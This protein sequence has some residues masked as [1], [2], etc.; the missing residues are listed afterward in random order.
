MTGMN[1]AF[2]VWLEYVERFRGVSDSI[3][4]SAICEE[5]GEPY[6]EV[7]WHDKGF[8]VDESYE[9]PRCR[10]YK[11]EDVAWLFGSHALALY[12]GSRVGKIQ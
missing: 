1:D 11:T 5:T 8:M 9:P 7:Y 3:G 10:K 6:V 12:F 4:N 2:Q